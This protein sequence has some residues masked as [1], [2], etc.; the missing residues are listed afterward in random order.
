[1]KE[2]GF[3]ILTFVVSWGLQL[4]LLL[5]NNMRNGMSNAIYIMIMLIPTL[6]VL[7]TKYATKEPLWENLWLKPEG[8]KTLPYSILGWLGPV[9]IIAFGCLLYFVI[10][11]EQFDPDMTATVA[12]LRE[13]N[14]NLPDL[15]D[16]DIV[17][18]L[19][20]QILF[21]IL[22]APFYNFFACV[23]EEIGWRG[24]FLRML[25]EKCPKWKAVLLNGAVW[26]IWYF[27][28]V[29][30]IG[31][32]YGKDYA[33]YPVVGCVG[34]LLYCMVLGTIYSFLTI[35]THSCIPA[36]LANACVASMSGVGTL[37]V[38]DSETVGV[39]LNPM[40]TSI[41]GGAGFLIV[42]VVI[43]YFLIK[44]KVQPVPAKG[45]TLVNYPKK[46][47][48]QSGSLKSHLKNKHLNQK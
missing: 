39:F 22:L 24:Y 5:T 21:N 12:S 4:V 16:K 35:K 32:N 30:M 28:M 36:I 10:F 33:G 26:G 43:M 1:M 8:R 14:D 31:L 15:T 18:T 7:V 48:G 29:I 46:L 25:C 3:L 38:K 40:P 34:T 9:V 23:G 37:F 6:A 11:R 20:F 47:G 45:E 42:A 17:S 13:R 2:K 41:I 44:D 27:P 19:R